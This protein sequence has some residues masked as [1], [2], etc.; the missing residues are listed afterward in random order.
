MDIKEKKMALIE[1][2]ILGF[3]KVRENGKGL[4]AKE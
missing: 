2:K 1:F 4:E 3:E